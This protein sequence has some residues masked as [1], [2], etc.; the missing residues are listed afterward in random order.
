MR[1]PVPSQPILCV[2]RTVLSGWTGVG[3]SQ[4]AHLGF[5]SLLFL[6]HPKTKAIPA[7]QSPSSFFFL[8]AYY[9]DVWI[10]SIDSRAHLDW[11]LPPTA[12]H[13]VHGPEF[14]REAWSERKSTGKNARWLMT[15]DELY[16]SSSRS[17]LVAISQGRLSSNPHLYSSNH[18]TPQRGGGEYSTSVSP[19]LHVK[20]KCCW[21][22]T[23][24]RIGTGAKLVKMRVTIS[25][26]PQNVHRRWAL[27]RPLEFLPRASLSA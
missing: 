8:T 21:L 9:T 5:F 13:P 22:G 26:G 11:I 24:P 23:C 10:N 7:L 18:K 12:P 14:Q 6:S 16:L 27:D 3:E 2:H 25:T 4:G 15:A 20:G 17:F 1:D 19:I